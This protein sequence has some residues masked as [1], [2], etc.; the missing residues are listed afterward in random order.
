MKMNSRTP[1]Q[2]MIHEAKSQPCTD[3]GI[4]LPACLMSFY[5]VGEKGFEIGLGICVGGSKDEAESNSS[6]YG[7]VVY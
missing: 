2:D 7:L 1:N 4:T 6:D 3:C 5:H